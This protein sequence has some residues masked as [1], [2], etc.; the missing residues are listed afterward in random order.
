MH[1][2][3]VDKVPEEIL[4]PSAISSGTLS[5]LRGCIWNY[6]ETFPEEVQTRCVNS[7]VKI[8]VNNL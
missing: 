6:L 3:R 7:L 4:I 2:H 5:T 1:P 8:S